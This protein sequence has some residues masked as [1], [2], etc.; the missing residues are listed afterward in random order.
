MSGF[1]LTGNSQPVF[2]PSGGSGRAGGGVC[3]FG[4]DGSL[5]GDCAGGCVGRCVG[6][7]CGGGR[8]GGGRCGGGRCGGLI[9]CPVCMV[10][11]G[12]SRLAE[13]HSLL[14]RLC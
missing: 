10:L 7:R 13:V 4:I 5:V 8:C 1:G 11:S 12:Q 3:G 2:V 9:V 14:N 6:G